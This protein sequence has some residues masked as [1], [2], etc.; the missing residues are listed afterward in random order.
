MNNCKRIPVTKNLF[1]TTVTMY[2][3]LIL[4]ALLGSSRSANVNRHMRLIADLDNTIDNNAVASTKQSGA[5]RFLNI[6]QRP[7]PTYTHSNGEVLELTCDA[8]GAPAPSIH[9]FKNDA[10]VYEYDVEST[11]LIDSNPSSLARVVSTLLV[12]RTVDQDVYTCLVTSGSKTMRA[13]TVVVNTDGSTELSERAKLY[14]LKPRILVTYEMFVDTI[15]NSIVLPCRAKGHPRP[16]ITWKDSKGVTIK[17]DPRMKVLRSGELVIS[18]LRWS[19]MGEFTCYATN[20]FGS[21]LAK[22]FVYPARAG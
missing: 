6:T 9:W 16:H 19:D 18:P 15:G 11:E 13:T 20:V 7:R 5:R 21:Q 2:L 1:D 22:T 3:F 10:P 17:K 12:S 14:P 4:A 8:I